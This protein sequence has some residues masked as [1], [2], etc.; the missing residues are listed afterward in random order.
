M[1]DVIHWNIRGIK[2]KRSP[3]FSKKIESVINFLNQP[4]N[5][6]VINIQETHLKDD[7]E[8]PK[9]W[10]DFGHLYNIISS[11]AE[12]N[13][14]FS[15]IIVFINKIHEVISTET[16]IKGRVVLIKTQKSVTS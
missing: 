3:L 12:E 11:H 7:S 4:Q 14:R 2:D 8:I 5:S 6:M 9:K 15:G 10:M 1:A 16:L 13:D